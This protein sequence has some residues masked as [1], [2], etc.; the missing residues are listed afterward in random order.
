M[1]NTL[2]R[3]SS[4]PS[5]CQRS[6]AL[7]SRVAQQCII[8]SRVVIPLSSGNF[9]FILSIYLDISFSSESK[10][11]ELRNDFSIF[12]HFPVKRGTSFNC[13]IYS[14]LPKISF[15]NSGDS[16]NTMVPR[17]TAWL[18]AARRIFSLSPATVPAKE[19]SRTAK[20]QKMSRAL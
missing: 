16:A 15:L 9:F 19:R 3:P 5:F 13:L 20:A 11:N 10:F 8:L 17:R 6:L 2:L 14:S 7:T 18:T 4:I 1:F 12:F